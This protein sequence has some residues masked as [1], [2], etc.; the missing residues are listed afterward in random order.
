MDHLLRRYLDEAAVERTEEE[1]NQWACGMLEDQLRFERTDTED[2]CVM[3]ATDGTKISFVVTS[4]DIKVDFR[5]P[6]QQPEDPTL[7]KAHCVWVPELLHGGTYPIYL[8][9]SALHSESDVVLHSCIHKDEDYWSVHPVRDKSVVDFI[10]FDG[11]TWA[12]F[13]APFADTLWFAR[14]THDETGGLLEV[15]TDNIT[16]QRLNFLL[17]LVADECM[18]LLAKRRKDYDA[19]RITPPAIPDKGVH[20]VNYN[21]RDFLEIAEETRLLVPFKIVCIWED[22]EFLGFSKDV[23]CFGEYEPGWLLVS[24]TWHEQLLTNHLH[25]RRDVDDYEALEK[26]ISR[27]DRFRELLAAYLDELGCLQETEL[28]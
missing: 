27:K 22:G 15:S 3:T 23:G 26:A 14:Y 2:G 1:Y 4:G 21:P 17:L 11:T 16:P 19:G 20:I 8:Q 10:N 9:V 18:R 25:C 6:G 7:L 13:A 24:P 12:E 28:V 5:F